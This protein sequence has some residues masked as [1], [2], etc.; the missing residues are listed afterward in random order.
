MPPWT[1]PQR[2]FSNGLFP[3]LTLLRQHSTMAS[4]KKQTNK[5][6]GITFKVSKCSKKLKSMTKP[7]EN[8]KQSL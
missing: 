1:Y 8:N 4:K 7:R 5:G 6:K 2:K 3:K